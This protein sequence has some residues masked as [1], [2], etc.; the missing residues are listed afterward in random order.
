[1]QHSRPPLKLPDSAQ[2]SLDI[3]RGLK[4]LPLRHGERLITGRG[5]PVF[6]W[7]GGA[8]IH[9][10]LA[11]FP[12]PASRAPLGHAPPRWVGSC[13]HLLQKGGS[14]SMFKNRTAQWQCFNRHPHR[15]AEATDREPLRMVLGTEVR[16]AQSCASGKGAGFTGLSAVPSPDPSSS[17]SA[18]GGGSCISSGQA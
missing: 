2:L 1:M 5:E 4:N 16:M 10:F 11:A 12:A 18:A 6:W 13:T 9:F 3:P 14:D 7:G 8:I 17:S 15:R